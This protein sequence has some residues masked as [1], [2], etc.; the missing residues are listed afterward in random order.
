MSVGGY[1]EANVDDHYS[2]IRVTHI[3]HHNNCDQDFRANIEGRLTD[4]SF[5]GDLI[6]SFRFSVPDDCTTGRSLR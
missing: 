1:A 2:G 5:R 6:Y 3:T 4:N